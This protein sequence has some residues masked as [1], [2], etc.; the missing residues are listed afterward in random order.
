MMK[1]KPEIAN[2]DAFKLDLKWLLE[3]YKN[4]G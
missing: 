2:K 3:R 1:D 4:N